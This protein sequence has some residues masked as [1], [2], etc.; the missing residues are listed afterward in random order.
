MYMWVSGFKYMISLGDS[1]LRYGR[2]SSRQPT[3]SCCCNRVFEPQKCTKC[4]RNDKIFLFQTCSRYLR[5]V[6]R[7][8]N[9][10]LKYDLL[11]SQSWSKCPP[12]CVG[13]GVAPNS[14]MPGAT[15]ILYLNL[16]TH[17]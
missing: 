6:S 16:L 2:V 4:N 1:F 11:E 14:N 3:D 13:Q 9:E 15:L 17:I 8:R 7:T 5:K 10:M 12:T